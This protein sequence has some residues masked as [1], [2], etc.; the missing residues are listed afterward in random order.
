MSIELK[1]RKE[2]EELQPK[3]LS[4]ERDVLYN[5]IQVSYQT[6]KWKQ[7]WFVML[8]EVKEELENNWYEVIIKKIN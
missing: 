8:K 5:P 1:T 2:I 7:L 3:I 4:G 6:E